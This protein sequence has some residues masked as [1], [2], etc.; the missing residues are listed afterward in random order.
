MTDL[1]GAN[2]P[3]AESGNRAKIV[4][5]IVVALMVGAAV[6]YTFGVAM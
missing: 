6:A 4:G 3:Q 5:A 1:R 2:A